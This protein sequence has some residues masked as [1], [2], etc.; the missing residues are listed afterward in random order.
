[1]RFLAQRT[2]HR[3]VAGGAERMGTKGNEQDPGLQLVSHRPGAV[4]ASREDVPTQG[5]LAVLAGRC[6]SRVRHR[7]RPSGRR[8]RPQRSML[9][10]TY[11]G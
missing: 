8:C 11:Y 7:H 10:Y 6:Q 4:P 3:H 5:P 1:M 9:R 2:R